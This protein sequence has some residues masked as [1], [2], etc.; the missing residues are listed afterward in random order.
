MPTVNLPVMF[1]G[2]NRQNIEKSEKTITWPVNLHTSEIP[3]PSPCNLYVPHEVLDACVTS[4][5]ERNN[6]G[7]TYL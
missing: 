4:Q 6:S 2:L 5:S 7:K 1:P 3:S